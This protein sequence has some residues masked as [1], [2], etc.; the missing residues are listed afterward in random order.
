MGLILAIS[1]FFN[2]IMPITTVFALTEEEK[3]DLVEIRLRQATGLNVNNNVG[4]VNYEG[5]SVNISGGNLTKDQD[6]HWDYG[7]GKY[8]NMY[9]LF[10]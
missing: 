10:T 8:G 3:E 1:M 7:G 5:G 4:T 2:N 9:M 6:D